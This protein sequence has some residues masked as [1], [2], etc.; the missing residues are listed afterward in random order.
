MGHSNVWNSH[1]KTYGPGSAFEA[2]PR[3][4]VSS[5][6]AKECNLQSLLGEAVGLKTILQHQF[7]EEAVILVY[8]D[9]YQSLLELLDGLYR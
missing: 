4:L 1:P 2:M 8:H 5:S 7:V 3:K 6:T 9:C